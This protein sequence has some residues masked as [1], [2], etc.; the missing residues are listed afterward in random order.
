MY[1]VRSFVPMLKKSTSFARRS[2]IT[3]AAGVSIIIPICTSSLYGVPSCFSSR[4]TSSQSFFA[5][6][7]SQT[8][9]TIGNIMPSLPKADA[10]EQCA[11]LGLENLRPGQADAQRA[12][13]HGG[14]VLLGQVEVANLL[15]SGADVQCADDDF[16]AVHVREHLLVRL[17][18]LVLG[19]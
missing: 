1:W 17:K 12:H 18:L 14:V 10:R 9:V 16:L 15:G 6:R 5:S 11:Q 19:R 8:D 3:A 2:L 4:L 7:T 13:T